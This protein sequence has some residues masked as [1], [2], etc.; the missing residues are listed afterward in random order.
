MKQVIEGNIVFPDRVTYGQIIIEGDTIV[1]IFTNKSQF[2]APDHK[3]A[4]ET[5]MSPGFIDIQI[6]GAF[7]KEFKTD[8]DALDIISNRLYKFGTTAFCPTITTSEMSRYHTHTRRLLDLCTKQGQT[9]FLGFHL[10]GPCFNPNKVGAQNS[11]LLKKPKEIDY[12]KYASQQ[13]SIVTLAPELEGASDFVAKLLEN[14]VK[15]GIGHS[16]I[17]YKDLGGV[18]NYETMI[19]VHLFNAMDP[20]ASREPGVAGFGLANDQATVSLIVDGVHTHPAIINICWKAKGDKRKIICITDG[21]AVSGL[22]PGSYQ[23]GDRTINRL[24]DRAVL[25]NGTLV[26]SILTLNVAARNLRAYT[27]CT[28][29]EAINSVSLNPASFLGI[30]NEIGQ[31]KIG[32]KADILVLDPNL[33]VEK[34]FID[35]VLKYEKPTGT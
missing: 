15:V 16:Q 10:E 28:F 9:K 1:D 18:F 8:E 25:P 33:E 2:L 3:G 12:I 27:G 23:V 29:S 7:G 32:N 19:L 26:G 22:D 4:E 30:E 35:G 14:G 11:A 34:T 21:S 17:S 13:V 31:I 5:F 24:Q 6:N 20:P